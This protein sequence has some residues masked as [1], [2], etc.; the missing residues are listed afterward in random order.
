MEWSIIQC[1]L[2]VKMLRPSSAQWFLVPSPAGSWPY[3]TV[4]R[5]WEPLDSKAKL[6]YD[7]RSV[8]ESL[9]VSSPIWG[10]RPDSFYCQTVTDLLMWG[11][12]S[13]ERTV[14]RLQ[15][16]LASQAR[17]FASPSAAGLTTIFCCLRLETLPTWRARSPQEEGGP[18]LSPGTES[19]FVAFYDSQGYGRSIRARLRTG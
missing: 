16:L 2:T 8:G 1:R 6:C 18:V 11:A 9:L 13:N 14:S 5:L 7:R 19:L 12:L 3:L 10:P 17:S 4:W 15:F